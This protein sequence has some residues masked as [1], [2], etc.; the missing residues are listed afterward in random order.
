M[1]AEF[2]RR[3]A[4]FQ[5]RT[6]KKDGE[7]NENYKCELRGLLLLRAWQHCCIFSNKNKL[8]QI[9]KNK[10]CS[11]SSC[12]ALSSHVIIPIMFVKEKNTLLGLVKDHGFS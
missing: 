7:V 5:K 8:C 10:L 12:N 1:R 6:R 9:K 11:N 2:S 3:G 4:D